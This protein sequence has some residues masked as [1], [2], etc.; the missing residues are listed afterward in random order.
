MTPTIDL[1]ELYE[2][3]QERY[4]RGEIGLTGLPD[5][6][7]VSRPSAKMI[8]D[9]ISPDGI[10]LCTLEVKM[11]RFVLAEFNTHRL[12]SRNAASSRAI[13][14]EKQVMRVLTDPAEPVFWGKNQK[15]MQAM[16]PLTGDALIEARMDWYSGRDAEV[17]RALRLLKL[18]LHKQLTNRLLEPWMWVTDIASSTEWQNFFHQRCHWAAQPEM[19][20][21][22]EQ[23]QA[24]HCN[25]SPIR[26]AYGEWHLPYVLDDEK[27]L[28]LEVLQKV[29]M[30]RCARVSYLTHAGIRD[31]DEDVAFFGRLTSADPLHASPLEHVATPVKK[32]F[33]AK[34]LPKSVNVNWG[35]GNFKGWKQLRFTYESSTR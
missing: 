25:S 3:L 8:L 23:I 26:I 28:S 32:P 7:T 19:R 21:A 33:W 13:P 11:H 24:A 2:L 16:E 14:I 27:A 15:G 6:E 22:S 5:P 31:R 12:F 35:G 30:A 1:N 4:S 17:L 9:S 20:A 10:R 18:G 34:L 29:S